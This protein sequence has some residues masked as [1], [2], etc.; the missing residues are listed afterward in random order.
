MYS[1]ASLRAHHASQRRDLEAADMPLTGQRLCVRV[2]GVTE[3]SLTLITPLRGVTEE[4][5]ECRVSGV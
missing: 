2:S 5:S 1:E 4:A 3:A